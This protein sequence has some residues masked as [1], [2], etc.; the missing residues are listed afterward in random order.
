MHDGENMLTLP[1][2]A[3]YSREQISFAEEICWV[4]LDNVSVSMCVIPYFTSSPR[5]HPLIYYKSLSLS[6]SFLKMECTC[7]SLY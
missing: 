4:L 5:G 1:T 6:I 7:F 2:M 3:E